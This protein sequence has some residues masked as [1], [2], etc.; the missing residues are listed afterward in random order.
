MESTFELSP[1]THPIFGHHLVAG[2]PTLP[3][4][5][6][7]DL[8]V[9]AAV[10]LRPELAPVAAEN[11]AF[12]RFV[13]LSARR[14]TRLRAVSRILD[15]DESGALVQVQLVSDVVHASGRVLH[16]DVRHLI[17]RV[18]LRRQAELPS[19]RPEPFGPVVE[20]SL[21]DPYLIAGS[22]VESSGPFQVLEDI[23]LLPEAR[24][25]RCRTRKPMVAGLENGRLPVLL[26]DGLIRLATVQRTAAGRMSVFVPLRC[27]L[28]RLAPTVREHGSFRISAG[29]QHFDGETLHIDWAQALDGEG[30]SAISMEGLVARHAGEVDAAAAKPSSQSLE[31]E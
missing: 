23:V 22:P 15:E 4:M 8:A 20:S 25:A 10:G 14:P 13:R 27:A 17:T 3:G 6:E 1:E 12:E 31:A 28:V 5:F 7:L 29:P 11:S 21:Y 24:I 19:A 18:R 26:A 30:Q 2:I 9:R 16:K